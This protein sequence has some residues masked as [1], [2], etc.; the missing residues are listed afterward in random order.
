MSVLKK[1]IYTHAYFKYFVNYDLNDYEKDLEEVIHM[2]KEE[3]LATP[4]R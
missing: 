4:R 3:Y 2:T 1:P